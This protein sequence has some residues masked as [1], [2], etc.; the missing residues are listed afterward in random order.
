MKILSLDHIHVLQNIMKLFMCMITHLEFK[1]VLTANLVIFIRAI[2]AILVSI[3]LPSSKDTPT[4]VMALEHV[5]RAIMI[6]K[7]FIRVVSTIIQ[8]I[9]NSSGQ[10]TIF[11]ITL[12]LSRLANPFRA[13]GWF[14][15][16]IL[17]ILFTVATPMMRNTSVILTFG[18]A[19]MLGLGTISNA[20]SAI[21]SQDEIVWTSTGHFDTFAIGIR[22]NETQV[23]AAAIVILARVVIFQ[24]TE[25]MI[26]LNVVWSMSGVSQNG[27][28]F[29]GEL[30]G[31]DDG[32]QVP[33]GPEQIVVKDTQGKHMRSL[34]SL[35]DVFDVLAIVVREGNVVQMSIS[36]PDFVSEEINGESIRP[37]Q[38]VSSS[39]RDDPT[40]GAVVAIHTN[41]SNVS[42]QVPRGEVDITNSR[43]NCNGSGIFNLGHDGFAMAAIKFSHVHVLSV[44]IN[45]IQLVIDPINGQT[46]KTFS[47]MINH[48]F[49]V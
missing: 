29:A 21:W 46:F 34:I 13:R 40:K 45:P 14:V 41:T 48:R 7:S 9:A 30:V 38:V 12:E 2:R 25:R 6:A 32:L 47:I 16:S 28:A 43:M 42:L 8:A 33:V 18:S 27:H 19:S 26:N 31:L 10:G 49:F 20:S 1:S 11:V 37:G 4:G 5:F 3:T 35:Q 36:P 23:R 17:A 44:T 39:S 15:R 22:S 24:L